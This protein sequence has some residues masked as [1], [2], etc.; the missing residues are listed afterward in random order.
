M[1]K[2][3]MDACINKYVKGWMNQSIN[4]PQILNSKLS[5]LCNLEEVC[6]PVHPDQELL[7]DV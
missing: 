5:D 3:C 4:Q 2:C 6:D 7:V 1:I